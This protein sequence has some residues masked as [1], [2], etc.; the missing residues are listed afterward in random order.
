MKQF[1]ALVCVLSAVGCAPAVPLVVV[2]PSSGKAGELKTTEDV[3]S[4]AMVTP[5]EGAGAILITRPKV[6]LGKRCTFDI[7]LDDQHVAGLRPG[8]QLTLYA[9]P[10]ERVVDVS[11]RDE[12]GCEPA[13]AQV[14]L[15]VISNTTH[16]IQ[17]DS[18]RYYDLKVEVNALGGSLPK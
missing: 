3:T 13:N 5:R 1:L 9:D 8:E 14:P 15:D 6:W 7:A 17:L 18:D 4:E 16:R 10:G 11:V 2:T 12:G